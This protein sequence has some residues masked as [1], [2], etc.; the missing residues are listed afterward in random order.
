MLAACAVPLIA[1]DKGIHSKGIHSASAKDKGPA[2]V[3]GA[4]PAGD[5]VLG[6]AA[7]A[8]HLLIDEGYSTAV[9]ANC[10][11]I[12]P[13][14]EFKWDMVEP[15]RGDWN[16]LGAK[17]IVRF[18][19]QHAMQMHGHALVWHK[20]MPP[21][22]V[23]DML[24]HKD[25]R[26]VRRYIA[27]LVE[28]CGPTVAG[29]DVVNEPLLP[30][31]RADGLRPSP[32]LQAF[33]P[34]YIERAFDDAAAHAGGAVLYLN[35]YGLLWSFAESEAKRTA[36]LRLLEQLVKGGAPIGGLGIQGH[37]E[38]A[39]MPFFDQSIVARF[40]QEVEAMGLRFRISELDVKEDR[41][42]LAVEERD[43]LV[44][45]AAGAL[46][47]VAV[48]SRSL[49]GV[50]C[51]GLSDRY[52]WLAPQSASAGLNR[53]LPLDSDLRQKSMFDVVQNALL[54]ADALAARS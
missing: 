3:T 19:Q 50:T 13:E 15:E 2:V 6:V 16:L 46:L 7:Q 37:L 20:S 27:T 36:A 22:A 44:A 28:Q 4:A 10:G 33:G 43:R 23:E 30:G 35:E 38:I 25:W 54:R 48:E 47:D 32:L 41:T 42:D 51:W 49:T 18:V 34:D 24:K 31:A 17:Q 45:E 11:S 8:R 9:V 14:L 52:S 1:A 29:W 5:V 39:K 53:G 12:T 26:I 40:L 21:W